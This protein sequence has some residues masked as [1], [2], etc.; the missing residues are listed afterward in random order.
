MATRQQLIAANKKAVK[1]IGHG[2]RGKGKAT[3]RKEAIAKRVEDSTVAK[4]EAEL[5]ELFKEAKKKRGKAGYNHITDAI[6]KAIK[7]IQLL[8]GEA[9][10]RADVYCWDNYD[11]ENNEEKNIQTESMDTPT[12]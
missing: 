2:K 1:S 5:A 8:S 11:D 9:T 3:L 6:D 4:L 10:E 7:N 12:T